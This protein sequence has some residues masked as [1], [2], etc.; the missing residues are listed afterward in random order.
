M[1]KEKKSSAIR[2]PIVT[3]ATGREREIYYTI[4]MSVQTVQQQ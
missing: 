1:G 2:E 4:A 3:E